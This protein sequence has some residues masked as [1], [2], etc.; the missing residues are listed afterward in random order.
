MQFYYADLRD[1]LGKTMNVTVEPG[2]RIYTG[3]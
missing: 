1:Y 3:V 2:V